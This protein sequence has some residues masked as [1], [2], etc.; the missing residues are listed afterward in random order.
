[1]QD[2]KRNP[3]YDLLF[4]SCVYSGI[5]ERIDFE[6][7]HGTDERSEE[8]QYLVDRYCNEFIISGD[9]LR[10]KLEEYKQA[11]KARQSCFAAP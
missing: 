5:S 4:S 9:Y 8:L 2:F 7:N 11:I 3:E 1:M 10:K 6:I